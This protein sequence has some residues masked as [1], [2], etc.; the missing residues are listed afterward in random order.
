[1]TVFNPLN[2][3]TLATS[4]PSAVNP[5]PIDLIYFNA[6]KNNSTAIINWELSACCSK[7]AKFELQKSTDGR[8]FSVLGWVPG[9]ETNRFY[10]VNDN[11]LVKGINYYRLKMIDIDGKVSYSKTVA[12]IHESKGI[13]IT[14]V[15]PNP[16][17][18]SA[19]V[20]V[21]SGQQGSVSFTIYD[22]G[23][24]EAKR[25]HSRINEGNTAIMMDISNLSNG[26]Y[27]LLVSTIESK[28]VF[29]FI[30]Q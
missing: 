22:M 1:M 13:L 16:V 28:T 26:I 19:I 24:K 20:T 25:W 4:D 27:Q 12:I 5:L 3:F 17:H 15:A 29:R 8:N 18:A 23:G 9:S 7:D 2:P 14:S 10:T 21:S 30:K 11:R 6:V